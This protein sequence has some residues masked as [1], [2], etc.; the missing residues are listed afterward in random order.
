MGASS[1]A[2]NQFIGAINYLARE[3]ITGKEPNS[4]EGEREGSEA[5]EI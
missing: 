1:A 4:L 3:G 5:A 2:H